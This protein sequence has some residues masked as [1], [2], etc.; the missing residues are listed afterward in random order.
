MTAKVAGIL[1][2]FFLFSDHLVAQ[3][4][5]TTFYQKYTNRLA[6]TANTYARTINLLID[7]K[8]NPSDTSGSVNYN[9]DSRTGYGV[10]LD[11]D[12]FSISLGLFGVPGDI[13]HKGET[14]T[15]N[16]SFSVGNPKYFA[17]F[18]YRKYKGFYDINSMNYLSDFDETGVYEQNPDLAG[19]LVKGKMF[20]VF[21][22][23]KFAIKAGYTSIYRQLRSAA[24]FIA[25]GNV[26][27]S[28]LNSSTG[29]V[30]AP[31]T[32]Q[33]ANYENWSGL[34]VGAIS[35]GLGGSANIVI[36]KRLLINGILA[37]ALETQWRH[38]SFLDGGSF[39]GTYLSP[40][41]D[42]RFGISYNTPNW[43][44]SL[45][46]KTDFSY[47]NNPSIDLRAQIISAE[48]DI[49]YRFRTKDPF[50]MTKVR[51]SRLYKFFD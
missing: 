2:L 14:T 19:A 39:S 35:A 37:V 21:N 33:Y 47:Y 30:P 8:F 51:Q 48:L 16:F 42:S 23:K 29:I 34:Y 49:A 38:Y 40:V 27:Y 28:E 45:Y 36:G 22:D 17:E 18:S 6:V 20:Y 26:Y 15:F 1:L 11:W 43:L 41:G 3:G 10:D 25:V 24:S 31:L 7:Q 44:V 4:W 32:S 46:T 5:D 12:I 13:E 50:L 9:A